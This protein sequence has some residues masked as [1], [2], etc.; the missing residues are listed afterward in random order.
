MEK[1]AWIAG[2]D[3]VFPLTPLDQAAPRIYTRLVYGF[4][5]PDTK[6]IEAAVSYLQAGLHR[7]FTQWPFLAGQVIHPADSQH[8]RAVFSRDPQKFN[9]GSFPGEVFAYQ[10]LDQSVFPTYEQLQKKG[11]APSAMDKDV[12]SLSPSHPVQG[13]TYHP[14]TLRATFIEGG[15]LL[16]FSS[17][18]SVL[19]GSSLAEFLKC[20]AGNDGYA[21]RLPSSYSHLDELIK[22]RLHLINTSYPP[23]DLTNPNYLPE[24]NFTSAYSP[25]PLSPPGAIPCTAKV[26]TF[27]SHKITT[28]HAQNLSQIRSLHGSNAFISQTDTLCGLIWVTVIQARHSLNLLPRARSSESSVKSRFATA[29]DIRHLLP[30]RLPNSYYMGNLYLRLM[31]CLPV[32]T[33]L[34]PHHPHDAL[35]AAAHAIRQSILSLKT[36]ADGTDS[37]LARHLGMIHWHTYHTSGGL[38]A[39]NKASS[40]ALSN[41][42]DGD[43][44][45]LDNSVWTHMGADVCFNIPGTGTEPRA[46]WVRKTYSANGG[47][48]NLLPRRRRRRRGRRKLEEGEEE[49][50]ESNWEVLL[51]LRDDEMEAVEGELRRGGFL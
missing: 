47:S 26:L 18:H 48:M 33:L 43:Y 2:L 3:E 16:G 45:G 34:T 25:P 35:A 40:E 20:F 8:A 51:A 39:L 38:D 44:T 24:Y 46:E 10:I 17:H 36:D 23:P 27:S 22:D 37:L 32:F 11:N 41:D 14:L 15:L 31:P 50:E 21:D 12:L 4:R 5:F 28:L 19:D 42:H 6:N 9:L 1:N 13:K 7:A 29:I 30:L 49:E